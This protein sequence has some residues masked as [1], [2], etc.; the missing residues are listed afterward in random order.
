MTATKNSPFFSQYWKLGRGIRHV[1]PNRMLRL[2]SIPFP[3]LP[4][5]ANNFARRNCLA[6][7]TLGVVGH[8]DQ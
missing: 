6:H 1:T 2:L 8:V 5:P 4:Y 3:I 7:V